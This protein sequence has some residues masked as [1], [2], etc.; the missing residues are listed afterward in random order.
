MTW[1]DRKGSSEVDS[2]RL[3]AGGA[4][5]LARRLSLAATL[6][7]HSPAH[8]RNHNLKT[9]EVCS[10]QSQSLTLPP[11]PTTEEVVTSCCQQRL[12]YTTFGMRSSR[13]LATQ[14]TE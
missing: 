14:V 5:A 7:A 10:G 11:I 1:N 3:V 12:P 6:A 2:D 9:R 4:S 13:S 8:R